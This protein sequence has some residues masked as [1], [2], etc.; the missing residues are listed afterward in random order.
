MKSYADLGKLGMTCCLWPST[1]SSCKEASKRLECD[2]YLGQETFDRACHELKAPLGKG[3]V[4][5]FVSF[6][7]HRRFPFLSSPW[8]LGTPETAGVM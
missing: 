2:Y 3:D 7:L 8:V 4:P 5:S 1:P 6:G